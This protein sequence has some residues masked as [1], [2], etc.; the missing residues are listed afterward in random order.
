MA[1]G[2]SL[3]NPITSEALRALRHADTIVFRLNDGQATIEASIDARNSRDGFEHTSV[4]Y[5]AHDV[6]DYERGRSDVPMSE[7][8]YS[9]F[10]Y[11]GSA[12]FDQVTQ[13]LLTRIAKGDT[14]TLAWRYGNGV[15]VLRDVGYRT[16]DLRVLITKPSGR[17]ETYLVESSTGPDNS[18]RMVKRAH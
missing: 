15:P 14:V 3:N 12:K 16:D 18:A 6:T 8:R 13:T 2:T 9:G 10:V 4:S 11:M 17:V 7:R 5:V 1:T